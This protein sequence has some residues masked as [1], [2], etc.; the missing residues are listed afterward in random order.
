MGGVG[1]GGVA[2]RLEGEER[3]LLIEVREDDEFGRARIPGSML[4]PLGQLEGRLN[5]LSEWKLRPVVVH[6]H[7]GGRSEKACR[8]LMERGFESIENME[9]GIDAWSLTIDPK[10]L[11]Y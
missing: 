2:G 1:V 11:R 3:F 5:E 9:G 7:L 4:V 8:L 6:C 10:V